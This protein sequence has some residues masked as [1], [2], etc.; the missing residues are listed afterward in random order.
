MEEKR[1]SPRG[2][3]I[4][5]IFYYIASFFYLLTALVAFF[6]SDIFTKLPGFNQ[7]I[8]NFP[9][10]FI[11]FG[12]F[13]FLLAVLSFFIAKEIKKLKRWALIATLAISALWVIGGFLSIM[14]K[15]YI[16]VINLLINL[17]ICGYIIWNKKTRQALF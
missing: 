3:K 9:Q 10:A 8:N 14:E 2:V 17:L 5:S 15:S 16:S 12:T 6:K 1:K 7:N 4:I 13:L 11:A